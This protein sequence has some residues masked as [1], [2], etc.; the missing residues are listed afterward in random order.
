MSHSDEL[1]PT[2]AVVSLG[3]PSPG[4]APVVASGQLF[5]HG[6]LLRIE[7]AGQCYQLRVTRENKLILTK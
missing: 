5:R 4:Q 3:T 2:L 6:N 7:H 1:K